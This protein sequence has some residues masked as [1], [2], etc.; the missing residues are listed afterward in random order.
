MVIV[1][2]YMYIHLNFGLRH[3]WSKVIAIKNSDHIH[4]VHVQQHVH[5]HVVQIEDDAASYVH[6]YS[7]D[8]PLRVNNGHSC[9]HA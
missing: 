4:H 5:V 8:K 6:C 3:L 1:H 2:I 7:I 9:G